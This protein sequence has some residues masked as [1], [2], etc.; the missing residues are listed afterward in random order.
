L[1]DKLEEFKLQIT[2]GMEELKRI[3]EGSIKREINDIVN[4]IKNIELISN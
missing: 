1:R 3:N 4:Q 2:D